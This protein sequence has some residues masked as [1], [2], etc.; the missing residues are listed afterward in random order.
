MVRATHR[1]LTIQIKAAD[2]ANSLHHLTDLRMVTELC[3]LSSELKRAIETGM[4]SLMLEEGQVVQYISSLD[5]NQLWPVSSAFET[6]SLQTI[7][8][9]VESLPHKLDA[10]RHGGLGDCFE[11]LVAKAKNI[12]N[13][14]QGLPSHF[15]MRELRRKVDLSKGAEGN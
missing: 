14:M 2:S 3:H 9:I 6:K 7:V 11:L 13:F 8:Y 4:Q 1:F 5:Q 15:A 12:T 10:E